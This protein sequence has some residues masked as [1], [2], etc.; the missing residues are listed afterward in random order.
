MRGQRPRI[1]NTIL[2]NWIKDKVGE[3]MLPIGSSAKLKERPELPRHQSSQVKQQGT[4]PKVTETKPLNTCSDGIK[5]EAKT[6]EDANSPISFPCEMAHDQSG[7]RWIS[8]DVGVASHR[9]KPEQKALDISLGPEVGEK[10]EEEGIEMENCW[11]LRLCRNKYIQGFL[12]FLPNKE[13]SAES[14][15]KDLWPRPQKKRTRDKGT[16]TRNVNL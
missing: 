11:V 8:T 12:H 9:G 2:K 15:G 3:L 7:V 1:T 14:T 16:R 13:I 6:G 5:P 4:K 10:N